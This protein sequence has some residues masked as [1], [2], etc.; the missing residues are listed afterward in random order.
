M[1]ITI[2]DQATREAIEDLEKRLGAIRFLSQLPKDAS[3]EQ[4]V[5][6]INVITNK[7]KKR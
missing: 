1:L 3:I 7:V 5:N 6:H 2:K 4:I